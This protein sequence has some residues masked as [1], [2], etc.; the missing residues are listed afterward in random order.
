MD[1][2]QGVRKETYFYNFDDKIWTP[3]IDM[4]ESVYEHACGI[5]TDTVTGE[6]IVAVAGGLSGSTFAHSATNS[7]KLWN[8]D[9]KTW[10]KGPDLPRPI[11]GSTGISTTKGMRIFSRFQAFQHYSSCNFWKRS[12]FETTQF[13]TKFNNSI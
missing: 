6:K 5:L 9:S 4:D 7:T 12:Y 10:I 13:E 8:L 2:V 3:G 1:S 11:Y